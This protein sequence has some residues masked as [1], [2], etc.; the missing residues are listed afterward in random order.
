M[1]IQEYGQH[2]SLTHSVFANC[3]L[4][5]NFWSKFFGLCFGWPISATAKMPQVA[6]NRCCGNDGVIT[7]RRKKGEW[8]WLDRLFG[9]WIVSAH[10]MVGVIAS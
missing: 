7:Y 6:Y 3:Q 1:L 10:Y 5:F 4:F 2:A 8:R 9:M